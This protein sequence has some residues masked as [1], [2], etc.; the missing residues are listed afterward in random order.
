VDEAAFPAGAPVVPGATVVAHPHVLHAAVSGH[1]PLTADAAAGRHPPV[2]F[3][4]VHGELLCRVMARGRSGEY[5]GNP[6]LP[7]HRQASAWRGGAA[8]EPPV[9]FEPTTAR[10][11]IES[12]TTELR[13]RRAG[14]LAAGRAKRYCATVPRPSPGG[15][16]HTPDPSA[17]QRRTLALLFVTQIVSGIGIAI[18]SSVGALL[19]ADLAGVG[20]SGLAQS[21]VVVG[22]ALFAVPATAIVERF[23]RRPSLATGYGVAAV[24]AAL[25]VAAAVSG[26]I[27]LLYA[28]FFLLGGATAASFQARYAATDLAPA[29]VRARHLSIVVWATTLGA[30]SGPQFAALAGTAVRGYGIPTLAGPFVFS[31]LLF[32]TAALALLLLLRPDPA[33]VARALAGAP[34]HARQTRPGM[35]QGMAAIREHPAAILG[36][37]AMTIGHMVMIAV[38]AM[39]AVH[40]RGAG[41][42]AAHTLRIVG[43]VLSSHIAGMYALSPVMGWLT[44]RLGRRPVIAL[45]VALLLISCAVAG[46]AG[47][48]TAQLSLGLMLLGLGWSAGMVAGSTLLSESVPDAVRPAAQGASDL[49]MGLGGAA[50]GALSGVVVAAYGYAGLTLAAALLTLPLTGLLLRGR[51]APAVAGVPE[52]ENRAS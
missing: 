6:V 35:R 10:L 38:M 51:P 43:I 48:Q 23:G 34:A 28:G 18:G 25:V 14:K 3:L 52:N 31:A 40:I 29:L 47:H 33:L 8:R 2:E 27:P 26:S 45:A 37:S 9:G 32:V 42:E 30:V 16:L 21:A 15:R 19:A 7:A 1:A 17:V 44:D 4:T 49:I 50:A 39:T 20:V 22:A 36:A 11:R 13:W 12:S 41:H 24:G 5:H 46:T